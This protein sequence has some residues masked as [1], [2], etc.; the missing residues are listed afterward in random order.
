M[1]EFDAIII[2]AGPGGTACAR[3]L[4]RAGKNVALVE[5]RA[6]GGTCLNRGCVPTKLLLGAVRPLGVLNDLA[7]GNILHGTEEVNFAA[8]RGKVASFVTGS[9]KALSLELI[10]LGV[11]VFK[12]EASCLSPTEVR[13]TE[14]DR[15]DY[16]LKGRSL[17]LA[18][19]T[20][21]STYPGLAPDKRIILGPTTL[22]QQRV[23]PTSLIIA[24]GGTIGV[25]MAD[26]FLHMG[27]EVTIAEAAPQLAPTEDDD[28][29]MQLKHSLERR[30]AR[31]LTGVR[32]VSLVPDEG[33]NYAVLTLADGSVHTAEKGLVAAGRMPNTEKL[34]AQKAGCALNRRGFVTTDYRLKAADT[35]WA[36]GDVNGKMLLAHAATHQGIYAARCILGEETGPYEPGPCPTTVHGSQEI[37]RVGLTEREAVA[38]GGEVAIS[39]A[40]FASN[41]IAQGT[42]N[43]YGYVKVVWRG[44]EMAGI[45][46]IG[47]N[48][49][50][51]ALSA[52][53]LLMGQYHSEKLDSFMVAHPTLD[54]TLIA[55]IRASRVPSK[56]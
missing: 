37:M 13:V 12:G 9:R 41:V 25:E 53:L 2:G 14:R 44:E 40:H 5:N 7:R 47:A 52:Q 27:T 50:Q 28:I 10:D 15:H 42:G 30:G 11:H 35:V 22:L 54:E 51:L 20:R 33:K 8:L 17:V 16:T 6:I 21:T 55:A 31:C 34:N 1:N 32:A 45:A 24:G 43:P 3:T 29:A 56:V 4:A 26:F 18:C 39:R 19:G 48:V 49:T 36:I 23:V 38:L 46:A